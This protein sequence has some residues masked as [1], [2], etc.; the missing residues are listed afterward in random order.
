MGGPMT[1]PPEPWLPA[2][3][4]GQLVEVNS[5]SENDTLEMPP[6]IDGD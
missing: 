2:L 3:V 5:S 6:G 4:L 1:V